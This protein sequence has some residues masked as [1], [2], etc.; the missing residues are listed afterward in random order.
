MP[1][2]CR[3]C[4]VNPSS[5]YIGPDPVCT[6]CADV[7]ELDKLS[8]FSTDHDIL[9]SMRFSE[10]HSDLGSE[11]GAWYA[12]VSSEQYPITGTA[13]ESSPGA[14]LAVACRRYQAE[15]ARYLGESRTR[16]EVVG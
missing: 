4:N 5:G 3:R 9:Q 8:E 14:A 13:S 1:S 15:V 6:D 16:N 10:Y 7:P 2:L 12:A 11:R